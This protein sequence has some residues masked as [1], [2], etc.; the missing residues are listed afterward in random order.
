MVCPENFQGVEFDTDS[1]YAVYTQQRLKKLEIG[2][3][4]FQTN[5][6]VT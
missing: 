5:D 2:N 4:L 3:E 1:F 6:E